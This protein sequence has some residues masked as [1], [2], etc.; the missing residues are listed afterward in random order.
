MLTR[1]MD[2]LGGSSSI[3]END[4]LND[5]GGWSAPC[6]DIKQLEQMNDSCGKDKNLEK[7]LVMHHRLFVSRFSK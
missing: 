6:T 5:I 2:R 7:K 3:E 4:A 1:I